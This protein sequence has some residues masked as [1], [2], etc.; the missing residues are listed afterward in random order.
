MRNKFRILLIFLIVVVLAGGTY[1]VILQLNSKN[2][3]QNNTFHFTIDWEKTF[4]G[5]QQDQGWFVSSTSDGGCILTGYTESYGKGNK[6]IWVIK[7]DENGD[8]QWNETYGL[9]GEETAKI[10]K[11]TPDSGYMIAGT[12]ASFSN[13]GYNKDI[14][15]I[16]VDGNGDEQWNKT[17]G[18][19]RTEEANSILSTSDNGYLIVGSTSSFGSYK[20]DTDLWLIKVNQTGEEQWNY[21]IGGK[22]YDEGRSIFRTYKDDYIIAGK[23]YSYAINEEYSDAWLIK[24]DGNGDEIWNKTFGSIYNELFNQVIQT[25]DSG[26]LCVGH[27][28]KDATIEGNDSWSGFIIKTDEN[29]TKEWDQILSEERDTGISSVDKVEDGYVAVGYIAALEMGSGY[30]DL[31]IEKIDFNGKKLWME[32]YGDEYCDSSIWLSI[33]KE[34]YCFIT[35]YKNLEVSSNFDLWLLKIKL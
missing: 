9:E 27:M 13:G 31:L 16:K 35:G 7:V 26:F 18:G 6:D 32:I 23:T 17:Y 14:W 4:G 19:L 33:S 5:N 30:D 3:N 25:E 15:L 1:T 21:T 34:E 10:I 11:Q 24:L 12:S 20:Y 28:Q 22:G 29:G 2:Y 8:E